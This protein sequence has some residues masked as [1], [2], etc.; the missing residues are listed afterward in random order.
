MSNDEEKGASTSLPA[1]YC[2]NC[3]TEAT[4]YYVNID[5]TVVPLCSTCMNAFELGQERPSAG[6][7]N[8]D[9]IDDLFVAVT[10]QGCY[11]NHRKLAFIPDLDDATIYWQD[12]DLIDNCPPPKGSKWQLWIEALEHENG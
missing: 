10:E 9:D 4:G 11:W 7:D 3:E 1:V 6:T 8:F 2:I 12:A 5:H